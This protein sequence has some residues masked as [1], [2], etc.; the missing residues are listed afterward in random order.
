MKNIF[1]FIQRYFVLICFCIL[2]IICFV[3]LSGSSKTHE[4][5]FA[6]RVN[7]VTGKVNKQYYGFR[8]YFSLK[9]TN[10]EL[11]DEN[12]RLKN[13]LKANFETPDTSLVIKIDT[14]TKDTLNR[15]RRFTY[16]PAKVVGN[17]INTKTNYLMLYRGSLQGVKKDM[18]VVSANG[19]VGRV[20]E[21]SENYCKVM[22]LLHQNS[23]V[24]AMVKK[25][26]TS[27]DIEWDGN[28][29]HFVTM[30]KVSKSANVVIGDTIVTSTYSAAYPANEMVGKVVEIKND[31][32]ASFYILKIKT[33][34]N[35]FNIQFVN[36]IKNAGYEEQTTLIQKKDSKN[37]E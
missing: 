34:T 21:V 33:A 12:A 2:Q 5:F 10:K 24:S 18:S 19:I 16:L 31:P 6:S 1:L 13:L 8:E 15:F 27:G 37:N 26:N 28:D 20:I 36:I 7:E 14:L 29:P 22:S 32:A 23:K 30:Q 35:F 9:Q 4:A 17:S 25:N 11:A 3:L